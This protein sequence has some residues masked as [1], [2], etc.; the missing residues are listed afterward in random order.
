MI[1][2]RVINDIYYQFNV[3]SKNRPSI[4]QTVGK[5]LSSE[6]KLQFGDILELRYSVTMRLSP[7]FG[8]WHNIILIDENNRFVEL[9]I[10]CRRFPSP[11]QTLIN[12][13]WC[14]YT[15]VVGGRG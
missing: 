11:I 9:S 3:S 14:S 10:T 4:Q 1:I 7:I 5:P 13:T 6:Y 12:S 2:A 15:V 8:Q